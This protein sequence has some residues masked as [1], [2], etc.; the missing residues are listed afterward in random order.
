MI[1]QK[2]GGDGRYITKAQRA[3]R[4]KITKGIYSKEGSFFN[5]L[6]SSGNYALFSV[7]FFYKLK[8]ERYD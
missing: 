2:N 5:E 4:T 7:S 1:G 8:M 3:D 6:E